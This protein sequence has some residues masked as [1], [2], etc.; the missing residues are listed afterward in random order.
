M[1]IWWRG[2]PDGGGKH[3]L[4]EGRDDSLD[5]GGNDSLEGGDDSL[6]EGGDDALEE[7]GDDS[8]EEGIKVNRNRHLHRSASCK[9]NFITMVWYQDGVSLNKTVQ[10]FNTNVPIN[11][12][13]DRSVYL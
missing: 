6:A 12:R 3:S 7:G 4:E 10:L 2:I 8:L 5:D 1:G 13:G 9:N 11:I